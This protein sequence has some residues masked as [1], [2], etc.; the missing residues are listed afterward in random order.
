MTDAKPPPRRARVAITLEQCWHRVP[1]GTAAAATGAISALLRHG[2]PQGRV[3]LHLIGVAARHRHPPPGPF[4]PPVPVHHLGLGRLA[5]Y[6]AWHRLRWPPVERAT[7]PIDLIHVT[8]MAMPPPSVPL[9]VTVNDLVF[10]HQPE[11][12][13]RRGVAFFSR[14]VDLARRDASLVICPSRA[15]MADC[16]RH[17]FDTDRLRLVPYGVDVVK[18]RP[19]DIQRVR[20]RYGIRGRYALWLGTIEPRKNLPRL[21][22]AF[23]RVHTDASLVLAGGQGWNED[24]DRWARPLGDR[25][26]RIGFVAEEDKPALYAGAAVFCLPSLMEGFGLPVLEAMAQGTPVVTSLG[27]STEELVQVPG[28][29]DL[30]AGVLVDP[31]DVEG[32]AGALGQLLEDEPVRLDLSRQANLVAAEYSSERMAGGLAGAYLEVLR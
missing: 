13:T 9:V 10:L 32:I 3:E 2:D 24:L 16:E 18:A 15:T 26:Q 27:T 1:G 5:L 28:V 12:F 21:L 29:D 11:L 20:E 7:G 17:G 19:F 14:A 22:A 31:H 30:T 8:G 25:V 23:G 6:E 4:V